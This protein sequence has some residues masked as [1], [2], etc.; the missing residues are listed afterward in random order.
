ME[1]YEVKDQLETLANDLDTYGDQAPVR[2]SVGKL[3]NALIE[4][5]KIA[6]ADNPVLAAVDE[7]VPRR[8]GAYIDH[9]GAG[10]VRAV[11]RQIAGVLPRAPIAMA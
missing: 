10:D 4:Q 11:L 1:P 7:F 9:A 8:D 3:A 5:A 2:W 6:L